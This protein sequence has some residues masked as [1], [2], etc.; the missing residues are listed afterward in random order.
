RPRRAPPRRARRRAHHLRRHRR[1]VSHHQAVPGR[2]HLTMTL[3]DKLTRLRSLLA[4]LDS[5]LVAFSG[6]VDSTFLLRVAHEVL[7]SRC[8]PLTPV[9]PPPPAD[10]LEE[11]RTLAT[12]LGVEHVIVETDELTISGYAENPTNRCYFCKDNLF[13]IC[14][15]EAARR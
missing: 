12:A 11:A 10:D 4:E 2:G 14:A 13:V 8:L 6:G 3:E 5:A 15:A 1:A 7:G 9:P